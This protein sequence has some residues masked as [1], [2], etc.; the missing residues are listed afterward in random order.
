M[1]LFNR[2]IRR[3]LSGNV[4]KSSDT[5]TNAILIAGVQ[6]IVHDYGAALESCKSTYADASELPYPKPVI[7]RAMI[8]AITMTQDAK[9]RETLKTSYMLL[10]DWQEGVAALG[11]DPFLQITPDDDIRES[12]KRISER[13][14]PFMELHARVIAEMQALTAE[15]KALGL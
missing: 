14:K 13:G 5:I 7:K 1:G 11:P 4:A 2:M 8:A 15:L 9:M 12:A 3:D 6:K 10:A